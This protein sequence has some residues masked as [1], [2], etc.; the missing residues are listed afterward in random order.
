MWI[1][2]EYTPTNTNTQTS[3]ELKV[4]NIFFVSVIDLDINKTISF[5]QVGRIFGTIN[6]ACTN[7]I[8]L[9]W[10]SN[11]L[12]PWH[13][14]YQLFL[15]KFI[16]IHEHSQLRCLYILHS[17]GIELSKRIFPKLTKNGWL[18]LKLKLYMGIWID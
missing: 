12:R 1:I 16:N 11:K 5:I 3:S 4:P 9:M 18:R 17:V 15:I 10:H 14:F 2:N 6:Y 8:Q 13:F 7:I